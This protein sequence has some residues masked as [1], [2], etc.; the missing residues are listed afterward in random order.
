M[1]KRMT[2]WHKLFFLFAVQF[3]STQAFADCTATCEVERSNCQ[4]TSGQLQSNRCDEQFSVCTLNCN[5]ENTGYCVYLG[6]KNPEGTADKEAEL[7]EITG[8]FARVTNEKNQPH[9]GGLCRS[10]NM[11]CDYVLGWD[12][13]M[14]TCGGEKREPRRV[15]CCR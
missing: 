2:I 11:R 7:K 14:Y 8:G 1:Y 10:A 4:K 3:F 12:R 15:A 9:F 5:R 13:T 6:F